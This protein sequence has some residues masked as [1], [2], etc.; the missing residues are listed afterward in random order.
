MYWLPHSQHTIVSELTKG[1]VLHKLDSTTQEVNSAYITEKPL[2]HGKIGADGFR[3]S[4]VIH[5]PQNSLPLIVGQVEATK[6]GSIIFL[7]LKLFP[8]SILYL[9]ASSLLA[10]LVAMVFLILARGYVA[11]LISLA[12]ALVNYLVLTLSF[13]RKSKEAVAAIANLLDGH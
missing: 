7:K 9:K 4:T 1:E 3:V 8:A 10:I 12:L 5:T 6:W 11:G 13:R 2:F